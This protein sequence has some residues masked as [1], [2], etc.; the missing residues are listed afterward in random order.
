MDILNLISKI[1]LVIVLVLQIG[2]IIYFFYINH[3][4]F[5]EDKKFWAYLDE[6]VQLSKQKLQLY[7]EEH[8]EEEVK[9]EQE[10]G[11]QE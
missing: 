11:D 9:N 2:V 5:E 4:R 1:L 6:E 10:T 3:K 7:S 8:L